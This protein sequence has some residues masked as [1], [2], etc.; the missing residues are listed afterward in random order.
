MIRDLAPTAKPDVLIERWR[1]V[2]EADERVAACW[3]EGSFAEGVADAF[4]EWTCTSPWTTSAS[5]CLRRSDWMRSAAS[6]LSS[7]STT[8]TGVTIN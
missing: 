7:P 2:L 1:Q 6:L 8:T 4:S 3:L 5:G